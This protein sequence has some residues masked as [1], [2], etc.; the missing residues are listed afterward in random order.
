MSA[1]LLSKYFYSLLHRMNRDPME[2]SKDQ[3]KSLILH[4][5]LSFTLLIMP[6]FVE[7][8]IHRMI[9][10]LNEVITPLYL[11]INVMGKICSQ[12]LHV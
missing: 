9:D 10:L 7:L 11:L 4:N 12:Q 1:S 5:D 3:V 8:C 6:L 2:T